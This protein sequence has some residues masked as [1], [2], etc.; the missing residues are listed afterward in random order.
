VVPQI[1]KY[2]RNARSALL[3][4]Q[5]DKLSDQVNRAYGILRNARMISSEET[6]MLLSRLRMGVNMGLLDELN[7]GTINQLFVYTQPAHLQKLCGREL[8][9]ADRNIERARYIRQ[10]LNP[11]ESTEAQAN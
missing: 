5:R 7:I 8:D 10:H 11:E 4:Q 3:D 2:E 6:M 9:T 1:I